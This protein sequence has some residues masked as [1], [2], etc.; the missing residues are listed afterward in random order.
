MD[1]KF[2]VTSMIAFCGACVSFYIGAGFATMQEI[3]QYE[4]SYGSSFPLVIFVTAIIYVYTNI[5]FATNGHRLELRRGGDIYKI[6]C[7]VF[8]KKFGRIASLFFDYFSAFFCYMSFVV[9][10]GGASSTAEQQWGL[11]SGAGAI[12]LTILV[13]ITTIFGLNGILKTL[14]KMGL[15]IVIMIFL[16]SV[17]TAIT[18]S[19][20]LS[21]NMAAIDTGIYLN[22]MKQVGGGN[23]FA[24]GASYGGFVI[25]WFAAFLAEIGAKN[26]LSEVNSGMGFSTLFIFGAASICCLALIGHI[27][28]TAASDI[29]ALVLAAQ[30]SPIFSQIYAMVICA[31]IYTSAVP[32][33]WTGVRKIADE[34][35]RKYKLIT[36][37]GGVFG[38]IIACFVPYKGLINI[39]YGLNGYLGF[40]LVFFMFIYDVKTRMSKKT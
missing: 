39:L 19:S 40:I 32:L 15:V 5:S 17:V 31:G 9:M 6:Y 24:S 10:C 7:G 3:V 1:R 21:K 8:G 37:I 35:T 25:L 23:P 22:V 30:I 33:L 2:S 4:A 12:I 27:D 34:G 11:P 38:C 16:V 26:K 29:P 18:G 20:N 28:I 14:G 36:I 13:I